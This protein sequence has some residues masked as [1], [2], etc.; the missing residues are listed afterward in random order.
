MSDDKYKI[1]K[2]FPLDR[3]NFRIGKGTKV[4]SII[5]TIVYSLK[6][7]LKNANTIYHSDVTSLEK[8]AL[9]LNVLF[10]I[11]FNLL[12]VCVY[13]YITLQRV[14]ISPPFSSVRSSPGIT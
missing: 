7:I 9:V 13:I 10:F 5:K 8:Y 4:I 11:L 1:Q 2:R 14:K 3:M 6:I 12:E